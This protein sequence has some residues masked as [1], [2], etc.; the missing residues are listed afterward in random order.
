MAASLSRHS[1]SLRKEFECPICCDEYKEPKV[2]ACQHSLCK[3][4]LKPYLAP[5]L[6]KKAAY[7]PCPCCRAKCPLPK[8]GVQGL[9]DNF[10][11]KNII[12]ICRT[13]LRVSSVPVVECGACCRATATHFCRQCDSLFMCQ[14]CVKAHNSVAASS[15][16]DVIGICST[17]NK[18][19]IS[20]CETCQSAICQLCLI[21]NHSESTHRIENYSEV[22]TDIRDEVAKVATD[23]QQNVTRLDQEQSELHDIYNQASGRVD[24]VIKAVSEKAD[25]AIGFVEN[26][27]EEIRLNVGD[28]DKRIKELEREKEVAEGMYSK[29]KERESELYEKKVELIWDLRKQVDIYSKDMTGTVEEMSSIQERMTAATEKWESLKSDKTIDAL[30]YGSWNSLKR[31]M[32]GLSALTSTLDRAA[33]FRNIT[34]RFAA[35]VPDPNER[36]LGFLS[37]EFESASKKMDLCFPGNMGWY[38]LK[39]V[40]HLPN[41]RISA[42]GCQPDAP[43]GSNSLY[44]WGLPSSTPSTVVRE[45]EPVV[46]IVATS[47]GN[48]IL[49]RRQG[50]IL[51]VQSTNGGGRKDIMVKLEHSLQNTLA[52]IDTDDRGNYFIMYGSYP[53]CRLLVADEAGKTL[54]DIGIVCAKRMSFCRST[55]ILFV[56]TAQ[57]MLKFRWQG[58]VQGLEVMTSTPNRKGLN[59][60]DICASNNGGEMFAVVHRDGDPVDVLRVYQTLD[61]EGDAEKMKEISFHSD[62][63][64]SANFTSFCVRDDNFIVAYADHIEVFHLTS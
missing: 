4:C 25:K 31:D 37:R 57:V 45:S 5:F 27:M 1:S 51:R 62:E 15:E 56:S 47:S 18:P 2:L 29:V 3:G 26:E 54:Q 34:T 46:D 32:L 33:P 8:Q 41:N 64:V 17:H 39:K 48:I 21:S 22:I 44:F 9:K 20:F 35:F 10:T 14:A 59:Y 24:S 40:V 53:Q 16:H 19:L 60:K 63:V 13:S 7:F 55:G 49:L 50:P 52:N 23:F 38:N 6:A 36:E 61:Q 12:R 58:P 11:L 30:T 42:L 28:I 43:A